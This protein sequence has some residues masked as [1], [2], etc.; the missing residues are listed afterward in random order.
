MSLQDNLR[1]NEDR[2]RSLVECLEDTANQLVKNPTNGRPIRI[3]QENLED[4]ISTSESANLYIFLINAFFDDFFF[5]L[6]GDIPY[7]QDVTEAQHNLT[8]L[9]GE[10]L[11][12]AVPHI[13]N[14]DWKAPIL[15]FGPM[16]D[17]YVA[18]IAELND[19][20]VGSR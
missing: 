8:R 4:I 13:K 15:D 9:L 19:I 3:L 5:N 17:A 2:I 16:V 18:K 6:S 11:Q 10:T 12:A 1:S 14:N 7:I 20:M